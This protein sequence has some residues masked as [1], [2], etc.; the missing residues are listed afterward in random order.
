[1][2][3]VQLGKNVRCVLSSHITNLLIWGIVRNIKGVEIQMSIM[4]N[5]RF[6]KLSGGMCPLS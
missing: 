3:F 1:M 2:I 5:R 4:S 6:S